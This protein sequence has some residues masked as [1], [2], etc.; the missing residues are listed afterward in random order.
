MDSCSIFPGA[1]ARFPQVTSSFH[2]SRFNSRATLCK[3]ALDVFPGSFLHLEDHLP[4]STSVGVVAF[5]D[6]R[7]IDADL[8]WTPTFIFGH[9]ERGFFLTS[10]KI[11]NSPVTANVVAI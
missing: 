11:T 10:L 4:E 3:D 7:L 5:T 1:I 6:K 2:V 8:H 9:G